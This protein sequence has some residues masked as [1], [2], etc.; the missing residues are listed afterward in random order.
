VWGPAQTLVSGHCFYVSFVDAFSRFTWLYLLK[1]KSDVY[2]VF[3]QFQKHVERLLGL[4]ISHV[5][6]WGGEYEK[7]HPFFHNLSIS[8]RV[9]CPHTHQQNGT[10]ECKHRHIVET[11]LTLLAHA[12]VPLCY[13]NDAFSKAY[14]LI[15]RLSS[16]TIDMQIPLER[17]L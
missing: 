5:T 8:H 1:H 3:L 17:L 9:S 11:D 10:A 15:N 16:R 2:D 6:D 4:K 13:W 12:S 14:F 7:V